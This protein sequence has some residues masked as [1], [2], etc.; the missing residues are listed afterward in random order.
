M[1]LNTETQIYANCLWIKALW[2]TARE[3][4][5]GFRIHAII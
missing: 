2:Y 5:L 1:I 3:L 4:A